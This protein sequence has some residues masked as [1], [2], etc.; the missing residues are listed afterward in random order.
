MNVDMSSSMQMLA[1]FLAR[2]SGPASYRIKIKYCILCESVCSRTDTLTIRKDSPARY[3]ILDI[4]LLWMSPRVRLPFIPP[5]Y[6]LTCY[7]YRGHLTQILFLT[8][9]IWHV[10][11]RSSSCWTVCNFVHTILPILEMMPYITFH[12][13]SI[14]IRQRY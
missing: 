8:I 14:N 1:I 10:F 13:F 3:I 5:R 7:R 11:E 12:D 6:H 4:L 2:F 9:S